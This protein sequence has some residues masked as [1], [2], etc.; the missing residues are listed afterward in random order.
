MGLQGW[1]LEDQKEAWDLI[2]EY[3]SLFAIH[4]MGLGKMS[5][6]KNS[7][8]LV[9][10]MPFKECYRHIPLCMYWELMATL[11]RC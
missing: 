11:R 3:A 2:L 9:E 7:I 10:N 6:V 1:S 8:R 5:L 4:D